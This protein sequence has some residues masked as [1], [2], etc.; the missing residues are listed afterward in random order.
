MN[1]EEEGIFEQIPQTNCKSGRE[2]EK[3]R[4]IFFPPAE[5]QEFQMS[6]WPE[7]PENRWQVSGLT[8]QMYILLRNLL[9]ILSVLT[10]LTADTVN[11]RW[12]CQIAEILV[13]QGIRFTGF[14]KNC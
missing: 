1:T 5:D 10:D 13:S 8:G 11:D 6:R 14:R 4:M 7:S 12:T 3:G 2:G 9:R